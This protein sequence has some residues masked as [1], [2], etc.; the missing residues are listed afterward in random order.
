VENEMTLPRLN[1]LT[2]Q[3]RYAPPARWLLE[4]IAE[5]KAPSKPMAADKG[6]DLSELLGMPGMSRG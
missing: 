2:S 5:F 3:W 1:D 6:R 4:Q